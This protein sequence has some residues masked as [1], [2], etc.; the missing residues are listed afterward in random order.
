MSFCKGCNAKHNLR[1]VKSNGND[2]ELLTCIICAPTN[3]TFNCFGCR[4]MFWRHEI[5]P[6]KEKFHSDLCYLYCDWRFECVKHPYMNCDCTNPLANALARQKE[7]KERE[8]EFDDIVDKA[9][10]DIG[11]ERD[12]TFVPEFDPFKTIPALP[13]Q[14]MSKLPLPDAKE[15]KRKMTKRKFIE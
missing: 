4:N 8:K 2:S 7:L 10:N 14:Y 12:E 5:K 9:L 6:V 1:S 11:R 13:S 15:K 3:M